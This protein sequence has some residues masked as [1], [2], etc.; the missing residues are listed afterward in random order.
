MTHAPFSFESEIQPQ[1]TM[2]PVDTWNNTRWTLGTNK[3][4]TWKKNKKLRLRKEEEEEEKKPKPKKIRSEQEPEGYAS[5]RVQFVPHSE[6]QPTL[7][8]IFDLALDGA[9]QSNFKFF[10]PV[11]QHYLK[12]EA[13]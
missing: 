7:L 5:S 10:V 1:R 9:T 13:K 2:Q 3:K 12:I 4:Y 8:P 11:W 6:K